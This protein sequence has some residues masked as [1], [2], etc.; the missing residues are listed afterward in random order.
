MAIQESSET[1]SEYLDE[2]Q[3]MAND[4]QEERPAPTAPISSTPEEAMSESEWAEASPEVMAQH[5]SLGAP[6]TDYEKE[7]TPF[8]KNA[9]RLE[10]FWL[11]RIDSMDTQEVTSA[12]MD[13]QKTTARISL[14]ERKV[15]EESHGFENVEQY[16]NDKL[17]LDNLK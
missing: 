14:L 7:V 6:K 12:F 5:I 4:L 17:I 8:R 16:E 11:D 13:T 15:E 9:D 10:T 3:I 2:D 1:M